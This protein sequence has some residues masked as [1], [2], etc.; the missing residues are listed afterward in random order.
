MKDL[1]AFFN[2]KTIAI[3]GAS[4]NRG[5]VG[6]GVMHNLIG[7]GYEGAVYPINNKRQSIQGVKAYPSVSDTPDKIDLAIITIPALSVPAIVEECG[8]VGVKSLVIMSSGFKEAGKE[9]KKL[10]SD[11]HKAVK[12]YGINTLGPNCLGF[13]RPDIHLNA[14]FSPQKVLK[15]NIAFI[16]QSGAL[17]TAIIDWAYGHNVGFSY[18]VSVGSMMD[19]DYPDLID[20]FGNDPSTS[21]ILIYMESIS[22][23]RKFLSAA[24][25][26]ARTKPII[27]LKSGRSSE[28]SKAALSHTGSLTGDDAV[29][30]AAFKR[31]GIVRVGTIGE[32][33][34]CAQT[35]SMQRK[36][37]GNRLAVVTNAGGPGVIA[38]DHLIARG[39]VLAKLSS[40]T[41]K[42]LNEVMPPNWS[43]GNPVDILGDANEEIF[44]NAVELCLKDPGS[45]AVLVILTPQT[46]TDPAFIAQ[47]VVELS[48]TSKKMILTA[49]MG[50][51]EV[52]A[53]RNILRNNK[54][55]VYAIPENAVRSF[56]NMYQYSRNIEV[57]YETPLTIPQSFKPRTQDNK[58]L[59]KKTIA[60]G[61]RTLTEFETYKLLENYEIPVTK[62]GLAKSADEAASMSSEIGFPVAMKISSPDIFHKTDVNGV[63]LNIRSPEKAREAYEDIIASAKEFK[64]QARIDGIIVQE[65]VSKRYE[66][67]IGSK[68]D[69]IF[70]PVIVFGMGGVAVE[71]F[72]DIN[73][74][75]PPLNMAL[76]QRLIEE[77]KI[78]RLLK[79][80]RNM[81]GVDIKAIQFLLYKFA[82][83]IMDFPEIKEIDMNPIA[84]DAKGSVVL[85]AKV[86]LDE[87][88]GQKEVRP[89]S[90]LVI[91]PYP[92]EYI[93]EAKL[94]NGE[95]VVLRPIRPED[96]PLEAEMFT[97]FSQ[98]TQRFRFFTL[99]KDITHQLLIRYTQIDYDREIAIIAELTEEGRKKMAGVVRLIAD[100][101]NVTAEFAIVVADPWHNL[102]LGNMLTDYILEIARKR[103]IKKVYANTLTDNYIM[104]HIFKKRGFT[105]SYQEDT[106]YVELKL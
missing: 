11:I 90:H 102:G 21:S 49:W 72:K 17:G 106:C 56:L 93:R 35:L 40:E 46:M 97:H 28:G 12:K 4:N 80:Y 43:K 105:F 91:S 68:D 8:Q 61:R 66:M 36:A 98:E 44:R 99:I 41:I 55:P 53:G 52:E 31:A 67:L 32:L 62:N 54:I 10:Y 13:L 88:I 104:A 58:E 23:A 103:G 19:I 89:Y 78:Y 70:G 86:V 5:S 18:F 95:T 60:E 9:G 100:A 22:Q 81:E 65:M 73:I 14:S 34:D 20:Y 74:G 26:F 7:Q 71:V 25:A 84:V 76:A 57:L 29:F 85:D 87:D 33:F 47:A 63:R 27:V 15:G 45:D 39:G 24:R 94:N 1:N 48:K 82:Y 96:E 16:S 30:D 75:L 83:L 50:E 3:I 42:S 6:Y 37:K 79:G 38:T 77:T 92:M 59:L 64:P 101:Y 2:P 69:P 51:S